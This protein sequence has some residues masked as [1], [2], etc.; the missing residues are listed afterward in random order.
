M[1]QIEL[2]SAELGLYVTQLL[3]R[4]VCNIFILFPFITRGLP[5]S[6]LRVS[7]YSETAGLLG[8][9]GSSVRFRGLVP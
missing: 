1:E 2:Q 3:Q 5:R 7:V 8:V 9:Y 4:W 6:L